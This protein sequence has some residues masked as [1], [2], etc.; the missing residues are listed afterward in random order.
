[1]KIS[2]KRL[3]ESIKQTSGVALL[4]VWNTS[5]RSP[6]MLHIGERQHFRTVASRQQV[7]NSKADPGVSD[8]APGGQ[9]LMVLDFC[10]GHFKNVCISNYFQP[11]LQ[12]SHTFTTGSST[13]G[14]TEAAFILTEPTCIHPIKLSSCD[15]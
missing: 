15:V 3:S 4:Q 8:T 13:S 2:A 12:P 1:M 6:W 7:T 11:H 14:V 10:F 9:G 5:P